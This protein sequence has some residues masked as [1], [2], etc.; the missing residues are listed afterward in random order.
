MSQNIYSPLS[1][2][3]LILSSRQSR[4]AEL[5]EGWGDSEGIKVT[6]LFLSFATDALDKNR[7]HFVNSV[8]CRPVYIDIY[9][10]GN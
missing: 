1:A 5:V 3:R 10:W 7:S 4:V 6:C 8:L 9:G 2:R